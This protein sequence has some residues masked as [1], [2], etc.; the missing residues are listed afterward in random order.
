MSMAEDSLPGGFS[1]RTFIDG[2]ECQFVE[3][4]E[5]AYKEY[6]GYTRKT[7]QYWRWCCLERPDVEREGVIVVLAMNN[8]VVGYVVAGR[9]GNLWEL[10][11]DPEKDG[12]V[13]VSLLLDRAEAYLE[14]VGASS[15]TF[16][17][18]QRDTI[19]AE[20][21]WERGFV[22]SSPPN[23]FLGVLNVQTLVSALA[24]GNRN[25]LDKDFEESVLLRISDAPFWTDDEVSIR[26]S[27]DSVRVENAPGVY[28][29]EVETDYATFS[30]LVFGKMSPLSAFVRSRVKIRPTLKIRKALKLFS[31]LRVG[32]EWSFQ[33][34]DYG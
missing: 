4:F 1:V 14:S 8:N 16:A 6:A 29:F 28:T 18:P 25:G 2:D 10:C 5:K 24:E 31:W 27:P 15:V 11:Y 30:S 12:R 17:A 33:L 34:S 3:L 26:I 7:P 32:E 9:L 13:I 22:S 20:L 23:M 21:C 19:I